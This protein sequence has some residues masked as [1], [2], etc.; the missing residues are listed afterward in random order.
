[1]D[2][3]GFFGGDDPFPLPFLRASVMVEPAGGQDGRD[4]A[5]TPTLASAR[6]GNACCGEFASDGRDRE[7]CQ[8]VIGNAAQHC[9]FV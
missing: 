8:V 7:A 4:G 9:R 6:C 3:C 5:G 1:M 2:E